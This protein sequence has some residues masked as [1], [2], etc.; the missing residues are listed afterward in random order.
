MTRTT[1]AKIAGSAYLFYMAVGAYNHVLMGRALS[2][3]GTAAILARIAEHAAAMRVSI[4]LTLLECL[5][6]LV[7][8]VALYGV[9]R[10]HDHELAMLAMVCRVAEGI[11][12]T[13]IV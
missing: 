2:A 4:L 1:N 10:A 7:V 9:T 13:R 11:I 3:E 12:N 6:A 5:S 8:A